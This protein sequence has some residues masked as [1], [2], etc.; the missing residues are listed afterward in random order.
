MICRITD[1]GV[2][3]RSSNLISSLIRLGNEV[4]VA[5][6]RESKFKKIIE[7][8]CKHIEVRI[9][10]HGMNPVR[11]MSVYKQY[12]KILKNEKPDISLLYTTKPNIYC[13][14]A[15]KMLHIPVIMNITGLGTALGNEGILQKLMI[16]LY[17]LSCSGSNMKTIFFQ[18]E[19]SMDF[20]A[21]YKIG[22]SKIYQRIPGSGVDLELFP[23]QPF[24]KSNTINILFI[25]RVMKEKGIDQF[26]EAAREIRKRHS[27]VLFHVLGECDNS[28]KDLITEE[29]DKGNIIY[30]GKVNNV[31]DYYKMA[32]CTVQP[33]FYP[34]GI[35][36]VILEAAASGRPVVTT[37][38]IGCREGVDDGETGFI[39]P[40][41]NSSAVIHA[42]E[43]FLELSYEERVEMGLRGRRKME[44]E[45]DQKI[46]VNSYLKAIDM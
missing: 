40:I 6:P 21:R 24:P 15:C 22:N 13:G 38:H 28:Y 32:Q 3:E 8:G 20:F 31:Q 12:Y 35:S 36:N 7:M 18:N 11:D 37:D 2:I 27:D 45:F 9:Q 16:V 33:S 19:G 44:R 14:L 17:K 26:L 1:E 29:C 41:K 23:L 43:R 42:I 4:I 30:H 46:I 25:A 34:E 10:G 5:T 39:V